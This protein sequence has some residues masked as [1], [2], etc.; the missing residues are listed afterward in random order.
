MCSLWHRPH[1]S[2]SIRPPSWHSFVLQCQSI[3]FQFVC[4]ISG[5]VFWFEINT[6][7]LGLIFWSSLKTSL[8]SSFVILWSSS[9]SRDV[10]T[11]SS[12]NL[13]LFNYRPLILTP[14]PS[15]FSF[16]RNYFSSLLKRFVDRASPCLTPRFISKVATLLSRHTLFP[17][18]LYVSFVM[19]ITFSEIP[20]LVL[21]RVW[22][23]KWNRKLF[24]NQ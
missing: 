20:D 5:F 1:P 8:S 19:A 23:E 4:I 3:L 14:L 18:F 9:E 2:V 12:P 13:R 7:F 6:N 17:R 21:P 22:I 11:A 15:L 16:R 10:S 24:E